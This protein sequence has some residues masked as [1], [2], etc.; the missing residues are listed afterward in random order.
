MG[1]R[2]DESFESVWKVGS[3]ANWAKKK[4]NADSSTFEALQYYNI[5]L[6]SF[7]LLDEDN[8]ISLA[9]YLSFCPSKY[10]NQNPTSHEPANYNKESLKWTVFFAKFSFLCV[11]F[12]LLFR[13][14]SRN[15]LRLNFAKKVTI[16]GSPFRVKGGFMSLQ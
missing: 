13:I 7:T 12:A 14:F 3:S 1:E 10:I 6:S 9:I 2:L 8:L 15:R 5:Y 16:A 4:L 11:I